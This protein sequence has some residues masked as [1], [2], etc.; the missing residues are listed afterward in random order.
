[1]WE[2]LNPQT[3]FYVAAGATLLVVPFLWIKFKLPK[4]PTFE[5]APSTA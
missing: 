2:R 1:M 5:D 4:Q 3:P